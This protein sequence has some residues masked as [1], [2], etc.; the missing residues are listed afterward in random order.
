MQFRDST[1][2]T[3][4]L[5]GDENMQ[6]LSCDAR[7]E[8]D[9]A[10]IPGNIFS[11]R[12]VAC[13]VAMTVS[14]AG[15]GGGDNSNGW[16]VPSANS[17]PA[18]PPVAGQDP[19]PPPVAKA[20]TCDDSMKADF[21][22]D[23]QTTV[24]SVRAFQKGDM[25]PATG[26]DGVD[27]FTADLCLVK[28]LV[29]PGNPGPAGAPSTSPGI[30]V[31]VWL[32]AKNAWNGRVH[33]VG[34]GGFA[35]TDEGAADKISL[36]SITQDIR[37]LQAVAAEEGAVTVGSDAGHQSSLGDDVKAVDGAFAMNPDGTI[38]TTLWQDFAVRGI[39]QQVVKAKALATA[40]YGSAPE[41]TYWDGG[42]T[43]G[44]QGLMLAQNFPEEFDGI[45]AGSPAINW[46]KFITGEVY[47]QLVMQ[48]DLGG[49]LL[50]SPQMALV[51]NAAIE[52][53]DVVGGVHLG[54]LLDPSSCRYDPTKDA[55]VLCSSSGGTNGTAAC[56]TSMQAQAINKIWYGMTSDGSAPD[57]AADNGWSSS[58]TGL[59]RWF[60]ISRGTLLDMVAGSEP[61]KIATDMLALE[62]QNPTIA[63]P[64][65]KNATGDGQDGWK[66]L[67][68]P[69]LSNAFDRGVS[70]QS[71]FANI[72]ADNPDLSRFKAKGG[73]LIMTHGLADFLIPPQ[74]SIN[75]YE[76]VSTTMGGLPA[77]Q[78]FFRFYLIPGMGHSPRNGTANPTAN[79]AMP[80]RKQ[81]YQMLTDWVEKSTPPT[82][83]ATTSFSA[84]PVQKSLPLCAYPQKPAYQSG[85]IFL[86]S[87]YMCK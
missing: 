52:A 22:P 69:Q 21:K 74:G 38:N 87:S 84:T 4:V 82:N 75:Y 54:Y 53:C 78:E 61:F 44:R 7:G 43:G 56:V 45:I 8:A 2:G 11:W 42:S 50:S 18:Q 63:D 72:N 49:A 60:G 12:E 35:G 19:A 51:S 68:Y 31:E 26:Y 5:N 24:V 15:C 57:P 1:R 80:A 46:T 10:S 34:N 25:V 58:P 67:T 3:T 64:T 20:L 48:R 77:V 33:A 66:G 41:R 32:P 39:Y 29:G 65:F 6:H 37:S 27:T 47:P 28:L 76:R 36:A 71:Q 14:L 79:P 70:L 81:I 85:D 59:Q 83:V 40:Y 9:R 73:R 23:A 86:A 62:L 55:S 13:C 30:G 16:F 17:A